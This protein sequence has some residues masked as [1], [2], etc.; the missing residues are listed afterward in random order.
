[1][2]NELLKDLLQKTNKFEG[3][4]TRIEL[5][6]G[7][8]FETLKSTKD[9]AKFR[10]SNIGLDEIAS[11][12]DLTTNEQDNTQLLDIFGFLTD[13]DELLCI[14][15]S[16]DLYERKPIINDI[17]NTSYNYKY[18]R[19]ADAGGVPIELKTDLDEEEFEDFISGFYSEKQI[20]NYE[21]CGQ[22]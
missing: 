22:F 3:K 16:S 4:I 14:E 5:F 19:S 12:G 20:I 11:I 13:S 9:V 15:L 6:T 18:V 2:L 8:D 1:M 17:E 21:I 7:E 10:V